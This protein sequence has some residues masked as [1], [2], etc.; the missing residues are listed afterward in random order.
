MRHLHRKCLSEWDR[1]LRENTNHPSSEG[2]FLIPTPLNSASSS[3][4]RGL[5]IG[6]LTAV[7]VGDADVLTSAGSEQPPTTSAAKAAKAKTKAALSIPT[8]QY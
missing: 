2:T 1:L 5:E 6:G 8:A 4:D 3:V 7:G